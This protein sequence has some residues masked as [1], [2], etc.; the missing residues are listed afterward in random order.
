MDGSP[1]VEG[2]L[3]DVEAFTEFFDDGFNRPIVDNVA[4]R[5]LEE[6]STRPQVIGHVI[7][8]HAKFDVVFGYPKPWGYYTGVFIGF[9]WEDEDKRGDIGGGCQV[10]PAVTHPAFQIRQ[11]DRGVVVLGVNGHTPRGL[12]HSLV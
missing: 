3:S 9:G 11:I 6:P 12:L 4:F 10:E 5:S 8:I 7:A 1:P 2:N